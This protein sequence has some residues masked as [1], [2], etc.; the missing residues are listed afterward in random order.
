VN[1]SSIELKVRRLE[2]RSR[3]LA[4]ELLLMRKGGGTLLRLERVAYLSGLAE[5]LD[6]TEKARSALVT[7]LRRLRRAGG[8]AA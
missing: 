6:G 4:V 2:E 5:A 7:V 1:R 8:E 3:E